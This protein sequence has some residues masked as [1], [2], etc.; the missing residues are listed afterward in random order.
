[1][2]GGMSGGVEF[3]GLPVGG[4]VIVV[5]ASVGVSVVGASSSSVV[6][7]SVVD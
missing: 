1:M 2:S 3:M 6:G 5:G 4:V 7:A